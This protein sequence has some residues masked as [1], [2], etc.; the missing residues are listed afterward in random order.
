MVKSF[1]LYNG[2][3]VFDGKNDITMISDDDELVQG[4]GIIIAT[5]TGEWFLN[6]SFGLDRFGIL[7][8]KLESE[9]I[10]NKITTAILT[11]E[12]RVNS[13]DGIELDYSSSERRLGITFTFSKQDGTQLT[14]TV[15]V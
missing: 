14:G 2:Q 6:P 9:K 5:N 12:P 11:N 10:V 7:G 13:V 4:V 15:G 8:Q 3:F 1:M